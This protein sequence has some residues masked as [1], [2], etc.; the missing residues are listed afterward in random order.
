MLSFWQYSSGKTFFA[1]KSQERRADEDC[2]YRAKVQPLS[3][4]QEDPARRE[5]IYGGSGR[6]L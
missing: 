4:W 3:G 6:Y 1:K 5:V 2:T